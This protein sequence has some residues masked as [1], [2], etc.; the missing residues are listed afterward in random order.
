MAP[1][2][3]RSHHSNLKSLSDPIGKKIFIYPRAKKVGGRGGYNNF[4]ER[5]IVPSPGWDKIRVGLPSEKPSAPL[6]VFFP[7]GIITL[8]YFGRRRRRH[9][10]T[11]SVPEPA[12]QTFQH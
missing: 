6:F 3:K 9:H 12:H 4:F 11:K 7:A 8:Y 1:K 5:K 10:Q 2:R